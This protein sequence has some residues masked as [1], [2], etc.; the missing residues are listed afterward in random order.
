L[1][2][3]DLTN[4]LYSETTLTLSR[5]TALRASFQDQVDKGK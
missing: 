3:G 5:K 2:E 4:W 1:I